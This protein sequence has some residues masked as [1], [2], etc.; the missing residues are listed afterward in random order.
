MEEAEIISPG[1]Y[2]GGGTNLTQTLA[3]ACE[4]GHFCAGGTRTV[5]GDVAMYCAAKASSPTPVTSGYVN[6]SS[7]KEI[8]QAVL[9]EFCYDA[10]LTLF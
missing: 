3:L 1:Y 10:R 6:Y 5:C 9:L 8:D 4:P 2:G 7:L